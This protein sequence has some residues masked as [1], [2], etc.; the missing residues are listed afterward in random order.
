MTPFSIKIM[1]LNK[2][3]FVNNI[4]KYYKKEVLQ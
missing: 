4:Y 1:C 2:I 3:S